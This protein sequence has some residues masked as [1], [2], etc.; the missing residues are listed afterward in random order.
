[1]EDYKYLFKIVLVGNAGVGK[2]CLVRK[3]TQGIFPPGQSATIGVDFMIKTVKV[4]DDKIKLQIWDTAGQ[5]RFR[6][7][8]Q[9]YYRSAHAIVLVYDVSCQPSF[10]CSSEWLSEIEQYASRNV[11]KIL[12]G[13][14]CDK[15]EER[16]IPLKVGE[17]FAEANGFAHFLETSALNST[18]VDNLFSEVAAK[19]AQDMKQNE[20]K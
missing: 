5:E 16:E 4:G 3:F 15:L 11:L 1:M 20:Y 13:N 6:S 17:N 14:K 7:I 2:T 10:D 19:L 8:T 9:S 18:N 12:V